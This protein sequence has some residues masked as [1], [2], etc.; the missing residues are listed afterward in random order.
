MN[1]PIR[2]GIGQ[3]RDQIGPQKLISA[4][5]GWNWLGKSRIGQKRTILDDLE[6]DDPKQGVNR[7][8]QKSSYFSDL[9]GEISEDKR[10]SIKDLAKSEKITVDSTET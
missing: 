5:T 8:T 9:N 6:G 7:L 3:I 1:Q 4:T 2:I 10:R